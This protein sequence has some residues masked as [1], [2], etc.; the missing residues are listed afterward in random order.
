MAAEEFHVVFD[1]GVGCSASGVGPPPGTIPKLG[2]GSVTTPGKIE[3]NGKF[4]Y[5]KEEVESLTSGLC[6][7]E[8][9][10]ESGV[11]E[12]KFIKVTAEEP[13]AAKFVRCFL[14]GGNIAS[15]VVTVKTTAWKLTNQ[16]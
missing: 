9:V 11:E 14:G 8:V 12:C 7:H 13:E 16:T 3:G 6:T 4:K 5:S 1:Q 15:E 10:V 2:G